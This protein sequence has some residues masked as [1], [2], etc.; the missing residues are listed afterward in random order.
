MVGAVG[1]AFG[2][3]LAPWRVPMDAQRRG[4]PVE[5]AIQAYGV[6]SAP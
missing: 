1:E 2:A 6:F 4:Q 3:V 5:T